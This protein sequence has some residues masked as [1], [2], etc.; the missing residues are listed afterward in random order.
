MR[1]IEASQLKFPMKIIGEGDNYPLKPYGAKT[2]KQLLSEEMKPSSVSAVEYFEMPYVRGGKKQA[3]AYVRPENTVPFDEQDYAD[4]ESEKRLKAE[5]I[6]K[7]KEE[8]AVAKQEA[9]ERE[10]MEKKISLLGGAARVIDGTV[11]VFDTETTGF[12]PAMGEELLQISVTDQDANVIFESYVRPTKK[13]SWY[14]AEQVHGITPEMVKYAPPPSSI[15]QILAPLFEKADAIVGH[16]VSFDVRF[17]EQCLGIPVS[18]DKIFDTMKLYKADVQH[19]DSYSLDSAVREYVPYFYKEYSE[20]AHNSTT[21]T[22]A[23]AKVFKAIAEKGKA[24][25]AEHGTGISKNNSNLD[26]LKNFQPE[27]YDSN[28]KINNNAEPISNSVFEQED[29]LDYF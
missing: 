9:K 18:E 21:D 23:T 29:D 20:G 17:V 8:K 4:I 3:Y 2:V 7:E 11:L 15:A 27:K 13:K 14:H 1:A 5:Q 26:S 25:I 22:V 16:N 6:A 24:L 19:A 12:S 10:K 28:T